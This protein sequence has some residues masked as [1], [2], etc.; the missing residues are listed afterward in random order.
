MVTRTRGIQLKVQQTLY[1]IIATKYFIVNN[2]P[3]YGFRRHLDEKAKR[4]QITVF[5]WESDGKYL[6][7]K[8]NSVKLKNC[9]VKILGKD[10]SLKGYSWARKR[11]VTFLI[12]N[13]FVFNFSREPRQSC[14]KKMQTN[15][16]K[17]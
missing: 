16:R 6:L 5:V 15:V 11:S 2:R 7:Q 14:G 12:L 3:Y 17:N 9:K 4:V 8:L 10:T 1:S 13:T